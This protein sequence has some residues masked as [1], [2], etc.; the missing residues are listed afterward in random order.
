MFAAG[1]VNPV[2]P[3]VEGA[4][5][6]EIATPPAVYPAPLASPDAVYAV[7]EALIVEDAKYNAALNE[8]AVLI[9]RAGLVALKLWY[10]LSSS[11]LKD[12]A[13]A[14]VFAMMNFL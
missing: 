5:H 8:S 6:E 9:V 7:V 12:V 1:V 2:V 4:F 14:W 3:L 10:A 13:I 11:P